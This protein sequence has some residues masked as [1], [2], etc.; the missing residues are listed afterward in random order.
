MTDNRD[1]FAFFRMGLVTGL[2][3]RETV[4]QWADRALLESSDFSLTELSLAGDFS[5]SR[6]VAL[7]SDLQGPPRYDAPLDWLFAYAGKRLA[8]APERATYILQGLLLLKA[9]MY[10]PEDVRSRLAALEHL[11]R[12]STDGGKKPDLRAALSDFLG[13]YA[14]S[15]GAP[16]D[17]PD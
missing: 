1:I 12:E 17:L 15:E 4:V 5:Y 9:E 14:A 7:L 8:A 13:G 11:L 2:I 3:H 10:L 16:V 6:M